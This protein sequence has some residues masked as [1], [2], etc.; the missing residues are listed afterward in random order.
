MAKA[1]KAIKQK[2]I[3]AKVEHALYV[4]VRKHLADTGET[5]QS[6]VGRAIELQLRRS[7]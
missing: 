5:I 1:K 7:A 2:W 3:K 6:F 4:A